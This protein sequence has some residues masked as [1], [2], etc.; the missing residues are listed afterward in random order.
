M[1]ESKFCPNCGKQVKPDAEFCPNC[2][3]K[4]SPAKP[5][6]KEYRSNQ[7]N[8]SVQ[9]VASQQKVVTRTV[10]HPMKKEIKFC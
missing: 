9:P 3:Q 6:R 4:L 1:S 2:G 8:T 7:T 5:S 10:H